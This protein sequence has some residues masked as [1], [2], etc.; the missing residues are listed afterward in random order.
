MGVDGAA[1]AFT[2]S[3]TSGTC[4]WLAFTLGSCHVRTRWG[5]VG[6]R[7]HCRYWRRVWY[8]WTVAGCNAT[9]VVSELWVHWCAHSA[10]G[11]GMGYIEN[12][13]FSNDEDSDRH[14]IEGT[15]LDKNPLQAAH[16]TIV[17]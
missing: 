8:M 14:E 9:D 3:G 1:D 5:M 6:A 13:C 7:L 4:L 10:F 12:E 16:R 2:T 17:Q 15:D 11:R